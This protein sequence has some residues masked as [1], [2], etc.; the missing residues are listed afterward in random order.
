[1]EHKGTTQMEKATNDL[2]AA[3]RVLQ[4]TVDHWDMA[5]KRLPQHLR[6]QTD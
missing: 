2:K 3:V 4:Q 1:M 6:K 5:E